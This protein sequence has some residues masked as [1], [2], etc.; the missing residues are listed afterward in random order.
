[1]SQLNQIF[2]LIDYR[3]EQTDVRIDPN[4]REATIP[5]HQMLLNN[6]QLVKQVLQ[7]FPGREETLD[8]KLYCYPKY[9]SSQLFMC[10]LKNYGYLFN[11]DW[12]VP[13]GYCLNF[14]TNK[15]N[16][17]K[18]FFCLSSLEMYI[19]LLSIVLSLKIPCKIP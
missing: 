18:G 11:F 19:N 1:M 12:L 17:E 2:Y 8:C 13:N 7:V 14:S 6:F 16:V 10:L 9:A 4:Y 5:T 3:Y 15:F